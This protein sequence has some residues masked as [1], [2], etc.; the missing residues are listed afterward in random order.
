MNAYLSLHRE[1]KDSR[2]HSA[3]DC[4]QGRQEE[5]YTFPLKF[6]KTAS[7]MHL[8]ASSVHQDTGATVKQHE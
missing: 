4:Q 2:R 7:N 1:R 6:C 5:R 8:P 3:V